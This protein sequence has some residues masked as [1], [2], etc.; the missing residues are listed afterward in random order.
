MVTDRRATLRAA[1]G[2]LSLDP[3]EREL[4]LR[5]RCFD[6]WRGI[7]DGVA[8]MGRP[9]D[10]LELRRYNGRGWRATF[11]LSGFEHSLTADAG[12]AWAPKS[13]GG[14][15]AHLPATHAARTPVLAHPAETPVDEP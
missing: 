13:V 6:T 2:F 5:H 14:G 3:R 9:E 11:F 1:L 8:G 4:R 7:G 12:S 10:D 15:A